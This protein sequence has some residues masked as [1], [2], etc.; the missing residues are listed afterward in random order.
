LP[1]RLDVYGTEGSAVIEGD[2]L[3]QMVLKN[4]HTVTAEDAARDAIA[5]AQGG[6][7]SVKDEATRRAAFG[8]RKPGW[9]DAHRAQLLD[10]I[11][12]IRGGGEPL[13][14]GHAARKP[15]EIV[16]AMYESARTGKPVRLSEVRDFKRTQRH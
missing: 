15:V 9:G 10:L 1:A 6:T 2:R 12:A 13:L 5:V 11:R 8:D 7:A 14:D 4:G 3:Q 16:L